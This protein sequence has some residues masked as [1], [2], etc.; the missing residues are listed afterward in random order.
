MGANFPRVKT[1]SST[2][3]VVFS[4]LNA[5]F[6]NILNNLTAANVDDYSSNITEMRVQTDPGESGTESLATSVAGEL[7][8]IRYQLAQITGETYWYEQPDTSLGEIFVSLGNALDPNRISA[9]A[10]RTDSNQ[11]IFLVPDGAAAE[12]TVDGTPTNLVYYVN[13]T[14]V[15]ISTDETISSLSVAPGSNNTALVN[16]SA[17]DDSESTKLFGEYG[18]TL[19]IDAAGSEI[20]A[21]TNKLAAFSINNG[22]TDEY[23][24]A[25]VKSSTE[26][27][28]CRRGYF[29]DSS[30][31]PVPRI[32]IADNDTL[33][34][35]RI[36][37]IFGTN[38]GTF[39]KV[40]NEPVW[41]ATE[42][43]SPV[44]DDYWFDITNNTWK[45]YNGSAFVSA[46]ATL[47]GIVV[48]DS[49]NC[50]GARSQELAG[51]ASD[52]NEIE[53]ELSTA[54]TVRAIGNRPSVGIYNSSV[55]FNY[56]SPS[57]D[58]T[59]NL[60][61]G[62]T[63]QSSTMYYLYLSEAG[64]PIISDKIPSDR[65]GDLRGYFHPHHMW[66]CVGQV[67]N[68]SS[69]DLEEPLPFGDFSVL[70][71]SKD[72]DVVTITA[73]DTPYTV[74]ER[75]K[76]LMVDGISDDITVNLPSARAKEGR[77]LLIKRT[78]QNYISRTT[79][80]D[81]DITV[82]SDNINDASHGLTDLVK[83]QVSNT[84]GA[85]PTGL[86]AATDYWVI[87]VDD[88]NYKLAANLADAIADSAVDIT[89]AAG[90]GTHSIEIQYSTVT[91]DGFGSE[92]IG[93][94]STRTMHTKEETYRLVADEGNYKV[95]EHRTDT[96][97]FPVYMTP[98]GS[99]GGTSATNFA[100]RRDGSTATFFGEFTASGPSAAAANVAVPAEM[101]IDTAKIGFSNIPVGNWGT[102]NTNTSVGFM[103]YTEDTSLISFGAVFSAA[104]P[105]LGIVNA[106]TMGGAGNNIGFIIND[107]PIL[108]WRV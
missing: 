13:G 37:W 9:G 70:F 11:P 59:V 12:A 84:G 104:T 69:S 74:P 77:E 4:D 98:A 88:D 19:T 32:A 45:R 24:L 64:E 61:S 103:L 41:Q 80:V 23:L 96:D 48:C 56:D 52:V 46:D 39:L 15:T 30:S 72:K 6:D 54:T 87:K 44:V 58:M 99:F 82:G 50:I 65:N 71:P 1:W 108:E 94:D 3:D 81:G 97:I 85:L 27:I 35:L 75:V 8:R 14:A 31:L 93:E 5:E 26:L 51:N 47:L 25:R 62:L 22:S 53:L 38:A 92:T 16:D 2:E 106:S 33:T 55:S 102:S 73:A 91:L 18:S 21:L 43:T 83:V 20:T 95:L 34:L 78:D 40:T 60:E 42:P 79:F 29:F 101:T 63:E 57:W 86:S 7:E 100:C 49:S 66:R 90:G 68:D 17:A 10:T 89:A 36:T 107:V 28:E 76:V 105:Q 67:Y